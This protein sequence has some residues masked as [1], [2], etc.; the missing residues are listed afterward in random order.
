MELVNELYAKEAALSTRVPCTR[1]WTRLT[2]LI[3]PFAPYI[4]QQMWEDMGGGD[5]P[6]FRQPWPEFDPELAR[7][8]GAEVVVQVNG[9]VRSRLLAPFGC[10]REELERMALADP[11]VRP[12][13]EGKQVQKVVVVPDKLVNIVV[14]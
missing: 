10:P 4:A 9:K 5:A 1:H 3:S 8:E 7:E 12:F 14:K 11:K 6:V 2:L 13:V